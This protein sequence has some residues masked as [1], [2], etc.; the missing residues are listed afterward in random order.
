MEAVF[1]SATPEDVE[2]IRSA[3]DLVEDPATAPL[4]VESPGAVIALGRALCGE[5]GA[6]LEPLRDATCQSFPVW[7]LAASAISSLR[8]LDAEGADA[9][10][11]RWLDGAGADE[12]D[13]DLHE[14][15]I[16]LVELR[17]AIRAGEGSGEALFVLFEE[18]AIP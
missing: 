8:G 5:R 9:V 6:A 11:E 15:S 18:K 14:L 10:A 16:C 3:D 13:A 7:T 17:D 2:R 12:L 4:R 1:F